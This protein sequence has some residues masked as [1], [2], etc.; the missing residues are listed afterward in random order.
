MS[1]SNVQYNAEGVAGGEVSAISVQRCGIQEW[2]I[3]TESIM[4]CGGIYEA[5]ELH[6]ERAKMDGVRYSVAYS[7]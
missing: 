4:S 6:S 3:C 1:H 2:C 5:W 7:T